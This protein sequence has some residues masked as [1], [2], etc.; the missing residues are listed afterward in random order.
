MLT[1]DP[2]EN[3]RN[4]LERDMPPI[5]GSTGPNTQKNSA[6]GLEEAGNMGNECSLLSTG[7]IDQIAC[8]LGTTQP[9]TNRANGKVNVPE[10]PH[11]LGD[12]G[13]HYVWRRPERR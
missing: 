1:L 2:I 8:Y 12:I 3:H 6:R 7:D 11:G 9:V 4:S 10:S 5:S 13:S